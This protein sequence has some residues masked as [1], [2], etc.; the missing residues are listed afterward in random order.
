MELGGAG[1]LEEDHWMLKVNL[2]DLETTGG[3]QEEYW[4]LAIKSARMAATLIR[5]QTHSARQP[6]D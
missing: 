5:V 1:L 2:G 6:A 3:E 4:L